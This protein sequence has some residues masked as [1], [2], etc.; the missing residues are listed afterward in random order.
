MARQFRLNKSLQQIANDVADKQPNLSGQNRTTFIEKDIAFLRAMTSKRKELFWMTTDEIVAHSRLNRRTVLKHKNV[1]LR[2][3]TFRLMRQGQGGR[4]IKTIIG[5]EIKYLKISPAVASSY[6]VNPCLMD[7]GY[8]VVKQSLS[9][10]NTNN[11]LQEY[12]NNNTYVAGKPATCEIVKKR[13]YEKQ[14]RRFL[15]LPFLFIRASEEQQR[16]SADFSTV[17]KR[18]DVK[19]ASCLAMVNGDSDPCDRYTFLR[20]VAKRYGK[21]ISIVDNSHS[22]DML[23]A[24]ASDLRET[25]RLD[26][27]EI[28]PAIEK[29]IVAVL[30]STEEVILNLKDLLKPC[31]NGGRV[32]RLAHRAMTKAP[33]NRCSPVGVKAATFSTLWWKQ[34][35]PKLWR[36]DW[37]SEV[38]RERLAELAAQARR[39][40][41][42]RKRKAE[43]ARY[44][45][46]ELTPVVIPPQASG[47][48]LTFLQARNAAYEQQQPLKC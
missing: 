21:T 19:F 4:Y 15:R 42:I 34:R 38:E 29:H 17:Q 37:A 26:D 36:H 9:D 13:H 43:L 20:N 3:G 8:T 18:K 47:A 7:R 45:E 40:D 41:A 10:T 24:F 14:R 22:L 6:S 31:R 39:D 12:N 32:Y 11:S 35:Y 16:A 25:K 5:N 1:H 27:S 48:V 46:R 44:D 2:R 28:I 33:Q 23:A 30:K